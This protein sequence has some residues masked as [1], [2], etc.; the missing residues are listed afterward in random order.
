METDTLHAEAQGPCQGPG[1]LQHTSP[2]SLAAH[3]LPELA[4]GPPGCPCERSPL[5]IPLQWGLGSVGSGGCLMCRAQLSLEDGVS[6]EM[7]FSHLQTEDGK[8]QIDEAAT[9]AQELF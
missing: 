9:G 2:R 8:A 3:R 6:C 7:R 4:F 5:V 1:R